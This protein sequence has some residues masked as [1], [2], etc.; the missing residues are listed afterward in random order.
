MDVAD[1]EVEDDPPDDRVGE[2]PGAF[3]AVSVCEPAQLLDHRR[4][5]CV[6]GGRVIDSAGDGIGDHN[7]VGLP[8]SSDGGTVEG[9]LCHNPVGFEDE[10]RGQWFVLS[11]QYGLHGLVTVDHHLLGSIPRAYPPP[12]HL[13]C[14]PTGGRRPFKDA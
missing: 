12:E 4:D 9:V 14:G 8:E 11:L 5:L 10:F 13:F 1:E 6:V 3:F 2:S 7:I